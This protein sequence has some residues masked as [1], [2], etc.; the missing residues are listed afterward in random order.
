ILLLLFVYLVPL[1]IAILLFHLD[2]FDFSAPITYAFF[3]IVIPMDIA[4]VWYLLRQPPIIDDD[5]RDTLPA[6]VVTQVWLPIVATITGV[7]GMALFVTD[8]GPIS[9]LWA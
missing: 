4:T 6:S 2:R 9:L 8:N 7:W 5:E 1:T 3:A